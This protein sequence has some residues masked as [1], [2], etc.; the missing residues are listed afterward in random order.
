MVP[1]GCVKM[2]KCY[3]SAPDFEMTFPKIGGSFAN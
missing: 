3:N 1:H 2:L